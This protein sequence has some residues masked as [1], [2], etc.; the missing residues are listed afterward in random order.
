MTGNV[1]QLQGAT[2]AT[3]YAAVAVPGTKIVVPKF[4]KDSNWSDGF[5]IANLGG[6]AANITVRLYDTTGWWSATVLSNWSLAPKRSVTVFSQA[7]IPAGF[8]GSALVMS[9]QPVAV[10]VNSFKPS[11]GG[12]AIGSY[13]AVHR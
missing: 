2:N 10:S 3:T 6:S 1:N 8:N 4:R 5:V 13:P 12:D 9:S 7:E 11:S